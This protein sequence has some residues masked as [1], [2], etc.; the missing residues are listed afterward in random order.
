[1]INAS[2]VVVAATSREL[3]LEGVSQARLTQD[4]ATTR[5]IPETGVEDVIETTEEAADEVVS[6][7]ITEDLQAA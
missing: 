2:N 1:M 6:E 3:A 7:E 5:M 4:A